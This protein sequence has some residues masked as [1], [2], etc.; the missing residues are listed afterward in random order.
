MLTPNLG[1][2]SS[3]G[4]NGIT[5]TPVKNVWGAKVIYVLNP[6]RNRLARS[7]MPGGNMRQRSP[8]MCWS[9]RLT[10]QVMSRGRKR[11]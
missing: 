1:F 4:G 10:W 9:K 11:N 5:P 2:V 3:S 7:T 6:E 8:G